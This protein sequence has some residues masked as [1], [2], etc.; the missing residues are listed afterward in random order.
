[1]KTIPKQDA[2]SRV[3]VPAWGYTPQHIVEPPVTKHCPTCR[4]VKPATEFNIARDK[5]DGLSGIC[6]V[7]KAARQREAKRRDK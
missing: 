3:F 7:C 1:M 6:R 2:N 4:T 5:L